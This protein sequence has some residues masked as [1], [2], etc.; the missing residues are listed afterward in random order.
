MKSKLSSKLPKPESPKHEILII[1]EDPL[2]RNM[3]NRVLK[4]YF[5]KIHIAMNYDQGEEII[6]TPLPPN[7]IIFSDY[8]LKTGTGLELAAITRDIRNKLQQPFYLTSGSIRFDSIRPQT[9]GTFPQSL[10]DPLL[11]HPNPEQT[12][13]IMSDIE[14]A[15]IDKTI[16]G[17]LPKTYTI[18]EVLEFLKVGK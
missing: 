4:T 18:K 7:S 3:L 12:Q 15:I 5:K 1:E 11:R 17:Y 16:E 10:S 14:K 6:Q 13:K 2:I 9:L 8:D